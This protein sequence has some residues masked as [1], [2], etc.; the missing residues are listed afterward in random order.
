MTRQATVI[1]AT[2]TRSQESSE[3]YE[4]ESSEAYESSASVD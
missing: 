3:A 1:N 2:T 4:S